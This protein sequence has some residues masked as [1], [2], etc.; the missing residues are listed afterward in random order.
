MPSLPMKYVQQLGRPQVA[1]SIPRRNRIATRGIKAVLAA[2]AIYGTSCRTG[3][4]AGQLWNF[5]SSSPNNYDSL[6]SHNANLPT[7]PQ[8]RTPPQ[9]RV[10]YASAEYLAG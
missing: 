9:S 8:T 7:E 3:T 6:P 1:D 2:L 4:E 10:T 5:P